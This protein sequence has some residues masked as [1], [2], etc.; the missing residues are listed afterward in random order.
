[1]KGLKHASS[2]SLGGRSCSTPIHERGQLF[3]SRQYSDES[4]DG[5]PWCG[6]AGKASRSGRQT[7]GGSAARLLGCHQPTP[8]YDHDFEDSCYRPTMIAAVEGTWF[9]LMAYG[10]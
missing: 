6:V 9:V 8:G 4:E 5:V 10:V 3:R 1:M 7:A 2:C